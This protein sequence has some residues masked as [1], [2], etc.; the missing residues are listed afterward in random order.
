MI[1]TTKKRDLKDQNWDKFKN[2]IIDQTQKKYSYTQIEF[3][4]NV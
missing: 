4:T 3:R 1:I 2:S